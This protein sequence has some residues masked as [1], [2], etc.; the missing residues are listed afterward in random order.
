M[1]VSAMVCSCEHRSLG[2]FN[3]TWRLLYQIRQYPAADDHGR[4]GRRLPVCTFR[5]LEIR[6]RLVGGTRSRVSDP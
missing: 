4:T 2:L 5:L 1:I 6:K 3:R